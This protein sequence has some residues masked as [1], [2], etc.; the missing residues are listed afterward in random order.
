MCTLKM[1]LPAVFV[2]VSC[3]EKGSL[4][5]DQEVPLGDWASHL[6]AT[7]ST[8]F[9]LAFLL[10]PVIFILYMATNHSIYMR[11]GDR[12]YGCHYVF[13]ALQLVQ[14]C[15]DLDKI[16][17]QPL[18][19]AYRCPLQRWYVCLLSLFYTHTRKCKIN[20]REVATQSMKKF[21]VTLCIAT[22]SCKPLM[23]QVK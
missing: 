8:L 18:L 11:E 4:K 12:C 7:P 21:E 10:L 1:S 19:N 15:V 5:K 23:L 22:V 17:I 20:G 14:R 3:E 16:N 9:C 2:H 13:S 6:R